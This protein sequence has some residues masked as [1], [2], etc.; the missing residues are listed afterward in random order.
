[1]VKITIMIPWSVSIQPYDTLEKCATKCKMAPVEM[2]PGVTPRV[3]MATAAVRFTCLA[4]N[5]ARRHPEALGSTVV[6][7]KAVAEEG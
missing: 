6:V 2:A 5:A 1:M 7:K 3:A 4:T